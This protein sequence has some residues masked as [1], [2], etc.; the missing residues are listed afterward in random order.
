MK[1]KLTMLLTFFSLLLTY[2]EYAVS[3]NIIEAKNFNSDEKIA[4]SLAIYLNDNFAPFEV[5][6]DQSLEGLFVFDRYSGSNGL[7]NFQ[8]QQTSSG[9]GC[10][11]GTYRIGDRITTE[12]TSCFG[13]TETVFECQSTG[14]GPRWVSISTTFFPSETPCIFPT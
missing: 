10:S 7:G 5:S 6:A 4:H 14:S 9:S 3:E 8:A 1:I 12:I 13:T 2:S 11:G